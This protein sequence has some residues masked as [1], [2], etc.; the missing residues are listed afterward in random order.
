MVTDELKE[1]IEK[2][3]KVTFVSEIDYDNKKYIKTIKQVKNGIE[4]IY[5]ELQAN[6]IREVLDEE[7]ITYFKYNYETSNT[8]IIY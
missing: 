4:Y 2:E 7:L 1:K 6:E 5:Y 8:N 3:N